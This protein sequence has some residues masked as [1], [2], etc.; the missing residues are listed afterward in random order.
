MGRGRGEPEDDIGPPCFLGRL[1]GPWASPGQQG[2]SAGAQTLAEALEPP[3][4]HPAVGAGVEPEGASGL[5]ATRGHQARPCPGSACSLCFPTLS[6]T[7]PPHPPSSWPPIQI[8]Q[9][10]RSWCG[11]GRPSPQF[12]LL[13]PREG[14]V[15]PGPGWHCHTR[16]GPAHPWGLQKGSTPLDNLYHPSSSFCSYEQHS[17]G[18]TSPG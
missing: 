9:G 3:Q 12:Q 17:A 16:E 7:G 2:S 8:C 6:P 10:I 5:C 4:G 18:T 1:R 15:L 11:E 13:C 14:H